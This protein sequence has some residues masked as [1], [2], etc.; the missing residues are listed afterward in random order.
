MNKKIKII[1]STLAIVLAIGGVSTYTYVNSENYL[2]DKM[3]SSC[4][5]KN[6]ESPEFCKCK[7][8]TDLEFFND[9]TKDI[10]DGNIHRHFAILGSFS[11][12]KQDIY[13][14]RLKMCR[15]YMS[16]NDFINDFIIEIGKDKKQLY[17]TTTETSCVRETFDKLSRYTKDAVRMREKESTG[18][19]YKLISMCEQ[20]YSSDEDYKKFLLQLLYKANK[21]KPSNLKQEECVNNLTHEQL[22]LIKE[23]AS[24]SLDDLMECYI[25]NYGF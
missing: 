20:H 21:N 6:P 2:I 17:D 3:V 19:W 7:A 9:R 24:K 23:H 18:Y 4:L 12:E 15:I 25:K 13:I 16:D 1:L 10:A 11:K 22:E 8:Y 5:D 14:S